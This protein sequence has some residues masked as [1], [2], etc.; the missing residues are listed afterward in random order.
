MKQQHLQVE[1]SAERLDAAVEEA[2]TQ[3]A[4][5]RAEADVEVLQVHAP[6][7][8]GLF[9]KRLARVRVTVHDRGVVARQLTEQLLRLS[10]LDASVELQS[11]AQQYLLNLTADDPSLLIGRHG[12]TLDAMQ[13]LVSAMTDR[14]T[15][16]RTPLLFDVA[17]YRSRRL[18]FLKQLAQRLSR[19]VRRSGKSAAT[20]PLVLTERRI[21]HDLFKQEIDLVSL[22]R[23]CEGGRKIIILQPRG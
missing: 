9:G 14:M 4:C 7:V 12:Q 16:D 3:L 18:D 15:T 17:G 10:A 8:F 5:T 20:P 22:S 2:L 1:V 6:G 19:K 21:L 23:S 13:T 11:S